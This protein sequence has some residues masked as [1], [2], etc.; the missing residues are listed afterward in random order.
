MSHMSVYFISRKHYK[1]ATMLSDNFDWT[2]GGADS[3]PLIG[4]EL[5]AQYTL[6]NCKQVWSIGSLLENI[7]KYSN[8]VALILVN[9]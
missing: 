6:A 5:W 9:S 3:E 2:R 8:Y 4:L 7:A 1:H